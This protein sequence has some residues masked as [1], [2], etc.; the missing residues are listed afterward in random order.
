MGPRLL[1]EDGRWRAA[2]AASRGRARRY[3]QA[4]FPHRLRP[5]AG[6]TDEL[7]RD[8]A[9]YERAGHRPI[10]SPA[11]ACSSAPGAF[12]A[13]GGFD[14]GFFLYCED[15]DLCRRLREAGPRSARAA[16]E[17][18]HVG[19]AS[20]GAGRDQAIAARSR[21]L[22]AR[23]HRRRGSPPEAFG[24]AL[25][26]ATHAVTSL[27]RPASRHGHVLALRAAFGAA[28]GRDA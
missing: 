6:W 14:E 12:E 26:E 3:A 27:R 11:P 16:A 5:R 13:I 25:G 4:L 24:V 1:D 15:T 9:A 20:S 23:K 21:V 17:V 19:G 18:R 2:S 22:L 8:P 28:G 7:I 10:G